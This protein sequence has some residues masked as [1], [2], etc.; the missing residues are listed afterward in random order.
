MIQFRTQRLATSVVNRIMNVF[1][2]LPPRVQPGMPAAPDVLPEGQLLD[3]QIYSPKQ[4]ADADPQ[5]A[6]AIGLAPLLK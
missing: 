5:T 6:D 1:D 3:Q 4:P 2:G